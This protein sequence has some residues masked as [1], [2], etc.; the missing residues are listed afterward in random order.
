MM[1]AKDFPNRSMELDLGDATL[2]PAALKS[3]NVNIKKLRT[4]G[5]KI[6]LV[7]SDLDTSQ[8]H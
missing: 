3:I 6:N 7:A 8:I 4:S 2:D 5:K 1:V